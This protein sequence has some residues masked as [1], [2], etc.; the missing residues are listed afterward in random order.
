MAMSTVLADFLQQFFTFHRA[1]RAGDQPGRE[2]GL[3]AA[4]VSA[5]GDFFGGGASGGGVRTTTRTGQDK[6]AEIQNILHETITGNGI[7]KA[8]GMELWE[9]DASPR[10]APPLPRQPAL[11]QCA[12]H[13]FAAD[14]CD[15]SVGI[16]LLLLLGRQ[17]IQR[18]AM[19]LADF[20]GFIVAVFSLYDP[21]QVRALLQQLSAGA[22]RKRRDLPL[23]DAQDDVVD[24]KRALVLKEFKDSIRFEQVDFAYQVDGERKPVLHG[25]DIEVKRGEV[26]ALVGPSGAG[27][28]SLV[29]LIPRFFDVSGGAIRIDGHDLRDVSLVSLRALIGKVTQETILFQ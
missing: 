16:A 9:M 17:Q 14:G 15:R 27:K 4:A 28:S 5:G 20:I 8:F 1:Y 21:A 6:L 19:T 3:G 25:I 7:V 22:G 2:A 10:G 29:N 24:K 12:G 23:Y 26:I 18:G 13:Q 11:G